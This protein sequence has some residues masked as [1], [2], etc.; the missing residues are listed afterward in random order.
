M[1]APPF[2]GYAAQAVEA[3]L[4]TYLPSDA[5]A[6]DLYSVPAPGR[7]LRLSALTVE[8]GAYIRGLR[9]RRGDA[10]IEYR[11]GL[12]PGKVY[13]AAALAGGSGGAAIS[14]HRVDGTTVPACERVGLDNGTSNLCVIDLRAEVVAGA[15][16][17]VI[18]VQTL[19]K[20][21]TFRNVALSIKASDFAGQF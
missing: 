5:R 13:L 20:V 1:V 2:A 15:E 8:R 19:P 21:R 12:P 11:V 14:V 7:L 18:R 10:P 4:P 9:G 17:L 6:D 16:E 3:A